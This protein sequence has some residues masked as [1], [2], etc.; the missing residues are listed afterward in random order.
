MAHLSMKEI[1]D[2]ALVLL[3]KNP[4]GIRFMKLVQAIHAKHPESNFNAVFTQVSNLH[5]SLPGKVIKP[6]RGLYQLATAADSDEK[7]SIPEASVVVPGGATLKEQ[8]FYAPFA[9]FLK[10]DLDEATEAEA[11]GGAGLKGKWGTPDV[12]G[13]YKAEAADLVKFPIELI[14]AEIKIDAQQ[15]V[16]A[17]GQAVAYRLFSHRTYIAMP[18]SLSQADQAQL[19][20][21]C[22]LFGVGLV[23]FDLNLEKPSFS[24]RMRAQR[25]SPDMFYV[26]QFA[27]R[28]REHDRETFQKLFR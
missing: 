17:F 22:M 27:D 25:F 4:G 14:S 9:V 10:E 18:N 16:V 19:E 23:L 26:N 6:S 15:P 21:L 12:I 8:D 3:A 20:A 13:A 7:E 11:L 24:I 28:L 1:R 2:E 5:K